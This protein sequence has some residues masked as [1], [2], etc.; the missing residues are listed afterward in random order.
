MNSRMTPFDNAIIQPLSTSV[1]RIIIFD[2]ETSGM[3]GFGK[4]SMPPSRCDHAL[5][6]S[7]LVYDAQ[8]REIIR[9]FNSYV[10]VAETVEI[11]EFI[12]NLN[13]C[14]REKCDKGMLMI[15]ILQEFCKEYERCDVIVAH[16]LSFDSKVMRTEIVRNL[17]EIRKSYPNVMSLFDPEYVKSVNKSLFC[18]MKYTI[19]LCKLPYPKKPGQIER[20]GPDNRSDMDKYKYPKLDELHQHLFPQD[21]PPE[22][23]HDAMVDVMTTL[24]CMMSVLYDVTLPMVHELMDYVPSIEE[25]IGNTV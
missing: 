14:T 10:K 17:G 25:N 6:V 20:S 12:S 22:G 3:N 4:N 21:V 9:T 13:H 8:T 16:N 5:Q 23:L 15:D 1:K 2:T 18:T 24:R 7:W 19:P 11:T